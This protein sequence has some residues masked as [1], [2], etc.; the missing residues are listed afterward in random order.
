MRLTSSG[1]KLNYEKD[2]RSPAVSLLDTKILLNR[3]I[4]DADKGARYCTADINNFYLNNP[5]K[6]YRYMKI[7]IHLSTD[8]ILEEYNVNKLVYKGY[9][10][11]EIWKGIYNLKDAEILSYTALVDDLQPFRYYP[12]HYTPGL[13]L[14]KIT[15]DIH[16][17][18]R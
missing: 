12:V 13:W 18:G 11:V 8:E 9:V 3:V 5:M 17:G 15:N 16:L 4:S 14:H 10:Y 6:T 2:S 7:P 1:D